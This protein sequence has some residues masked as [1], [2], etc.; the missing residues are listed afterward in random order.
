[1]VFPASN[2]VSV[3]FG[4]KHRLWVLRHLQGRM[5]YA[6]YATAWMC[7]INFAN[8]YGDV[9][10]SEPFVLNNVSMMHFFSC[11]MGRKSD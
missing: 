4:I 8:H 1:M 3:V 2:V 5:A 9:S 10:K 11:G 6:R 7:R